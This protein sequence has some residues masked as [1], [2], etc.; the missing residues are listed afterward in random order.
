MLHTPDIGAGGAPVLAAMRD[1]HFLAGGWDRTMWMFYSGFSIT[2]FILLVLIAV[3]LWQLAR[4]GARVGNAH[5]RPFMF[6]LA[7]ALGAVA[8]VSAVLLVWP[9]TVICGIAALLTAAGAFSGHDATQRKR[10]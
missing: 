1:Y 8:A 3:L 6:T 10:A 4:A 7:L 9:P 5:L 2:V